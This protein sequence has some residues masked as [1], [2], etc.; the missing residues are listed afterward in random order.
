MERLPR[1]EALRDRGIGMLSLKDTLLHI[2]RVHD[3]WLNYI[4]PGDLAGLRASHDVFQ[5]V[6]TPREVHAYMRAAWR[7]IARRMARLT[8]RELARVVKAPWMPGR[9]TLADALMQCSL[10]QAHHIGEIIGAMWQEDTACPQMMW[11]PTLTG[12]TVS[13]R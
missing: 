12:R 1:R 13:V 11:I 2:V 8:E 6:R 9:Y 5:R 7:P 10:E 3:A 4:V